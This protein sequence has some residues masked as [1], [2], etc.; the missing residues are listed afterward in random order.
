MTTTSY[1]VAGLTC[2]ACIAEVMEHVRALAGVTGVAVELVRDGP[3][4][5]VVTAGP[6]VGIGE[7]RAAV[8][9]AG[10]DLTGQWTEKTAHGTRHSPDG[11]LPERT[12]TENSILG[13]ER[14]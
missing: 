7:V 13:G 11:S 1:E 12:G 4:P 9:E 10:F 3:S 5:V 6:S 8:G 2:G 14:S